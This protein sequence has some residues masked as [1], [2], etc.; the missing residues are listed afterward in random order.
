MLRAT[1][2]F[3]NKMHRKAKKI[4][5]IGAGGLAKQMLWDI[6]AFGYLPTFYDDIFVN[7]NDPFWGHSRYKVV[8]SSAGHKTFMVG[9]SDPKKREQITRK[10]HSLGFNSLGLISSTVHIPL[11]SKKDRDVVVLRECVIEPFT[12]I[13]RGSLLNVG[14]YFHHN[15]T[16]W[17]FL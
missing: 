12:E 16:M 3:F 15:H 11:S 1:D 4:L 17:Q 8:R 5:V 14:V 9:L 13:G 2:L 10:F 6:L 7:H